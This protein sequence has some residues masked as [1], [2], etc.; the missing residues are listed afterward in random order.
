METKK[1]KETKNELVDDS[2]INGLILDL[3]KMDDDL[4]VKEYLIEGGVSSANKI[5][6]FIRKSAK[7]QYTE[8]GYA[9]VIIDYI[10]S[11]LNKA[12]ENPKLEFKVPFNVAQY[13]V[14]FLSRYDGKGI[15]NKSYGYLELLNLMSNV[16]R[17]INED[18]NKY[19]DLQ[20]QIDNLTAQKAENIN[21]DIN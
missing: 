9:V 16:Q 13:I 11:F 7:W 14:L 17:E 10:E 12:K 18:Y 20:T 1:T 3:K 4:N 6:D 15:N 21:N 8:I 2:L 19:H 5:L